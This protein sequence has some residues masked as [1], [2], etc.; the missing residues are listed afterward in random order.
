[1][2]IFARGLLSI[3]CGILGDITDVKG[4]DKEIRPFIL[5]D[6]FR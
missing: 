3:L 4:T 5:V 2:N 1:M 6:C